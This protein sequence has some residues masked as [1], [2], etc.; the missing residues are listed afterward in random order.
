MSLCLCPS[1]CSHVSPDASISPHSVSRLHIASLSP[2][3]ISLTLKVFSTQKQPLVWVSLRHSVSCFTFGSLVRFLF[4]FVCLFCKLAHLQLCCRPHLPTFMCVSP[5][6]LH[7]DL[8]HGCVFVCEL[9]FV[10]Y[11]GRVLYLFFLHAIKMDVFEPQSCLLHTV[12]DNLFATSFFCLNIWLH[13]LTYLTAHMSV[14]VPS[15][16]IIL[17]GLKTSVWITEA[18]T[19]VY[20]HRLVVIMTPCWSRSNIYWL[21]YSSEDSH[22]RKLGH[23]MKTCIL[24]NIFGHIDI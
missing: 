24:Y 2:P 10:F 15:N 12:H 6:V 13:L 19:S 14:H 11:P 20:C 3:I 4:S 16:I 17:F 9:S 23:P 1:V 21:N 8:P 7:R 18:T 22:M 5:S